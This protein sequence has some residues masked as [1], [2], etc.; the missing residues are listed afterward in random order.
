MRT[1]LT[2]DTD[3]AERLR[4][5]MAERKCSLKEAVNEIM[6]QGLRAGSPAP[7]PPPFRVVPHDCGFQPGI[8]QFQLQKVLDEMEAGD[9][10]RKY[11]RQQRRAAKP[12]VAKKSAR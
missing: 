2:L 7:P 11:Q 8:D 9:F 6:R 10:W 4:A 5:R 3:V 12:P 1:T